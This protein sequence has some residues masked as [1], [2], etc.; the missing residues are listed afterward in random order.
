[1][2]RVKRRVRSRPDIESEVGV[3]QHV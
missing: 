3:M 2:G 1:M